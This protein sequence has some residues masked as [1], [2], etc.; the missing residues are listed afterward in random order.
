MV[1]VEELEG[2]SFSLKTT[3]AIAANNNFLYSSVTLSRLII[4]NNVT[5]GHE[6]F[7]FYL[8]I[9]IYKFL[10]FEVAYA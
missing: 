5:S 10:Y 2:G 9:F 6:K 7:T 3:A 8:Y 1:V 4:F